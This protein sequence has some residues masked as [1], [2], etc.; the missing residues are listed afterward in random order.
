MPERQDLRLRTRI[1][2][3][4][5]HFHSARPGDEEMWGSGFLVAP[6]WALTCAHVL[7][8][9]IGA[10]GGDEFRVRGPGLHDGRPVAAR[11]AASLY[12]GDLGAERDDWTSVPV[13]QDLALVRLTDPSVRHEC[14]WLSDRSDHPLGEGRVVHGY[15]PADGGAASAWSGSAEVSS[16]D[17]P[18]G[19]RLGPTNTFPE[20]V[21]GGPVLDSATGA[22]VAVIKSRVAGDTGGL[23]IAVSLM[24]RFEEHYPAIVAA[25]DAWHHAQRKE[26]HNWVGRQLELPGA[27][28][29]AGDHWSPLDRRTALALLAEVPPPDAP[30]T[31]TL[32]VRQAR[33]D[34]PPGR[35]HLPLTWRDGHGLLYEGD[36]PQ[37][38]FVL[39]RYL[40]LVQLF[41]QSREPRPPSREPGSPASES[42]AVRRL[43]D[44]IE[45]R[46]E[47]VPPSLH[48]TV[49]D[50][51]LPAGLVPSGRGGAVGPYPERPVVLLELEPLDDDHSRVYWT[52]RVDDGGEDSDVPRDGDTTGPGVE[53]A[54][55]RS[56]IARPLAAAFRA[57]DTPE[58]P[59]PLEVALD[60]RHFDTPVHEWQIYDSAPLWDTARQQLLGVRRPVVIRDIGRRGVPAESW[61]RRWEG[62]LARGRLTARPTVFGDGGAGDQH[63][64]EHDFAGLGPGEVP[65]QCRRAGT[66]AG[67]PAMRRVLDAG[68][69]VALWHHGDHAGP[70]CGP[71]CDALHR[72]TADFLAEVGHPAELPERLRR[73]REHISKG[74][75]RHWADTLA[76]LYDDPARPLPAEDGVFDAP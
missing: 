61:E 19:L 7:L 5:V 17:G 42:G 40:R 58:L 27:A 52:L 75:G 65:V 50:A 2:N 6:G 26:P 66:G 57:V 45:D 28:T 35:P 60:P 12:E 73:I 15:R 59:A 56:V 23:S 41:V 34:D 1:E 30:H 67:H 31:V 37:G 3:A 49:L 72:S 53:L 69:G 18:Y 24:R 10:A 21:S 48:T 11:L 64:G 32:L 47:P 39:L 20:G 63:A 76:V 62:M 74:N 13:E 4:T 51:V 71:G 25:H 22:V 70:W 43:G 55:L 29:R 8:G 46:L 54:R 16:Q 68:H 38:A 9:R 44:W 36:Q 33:G 14:V